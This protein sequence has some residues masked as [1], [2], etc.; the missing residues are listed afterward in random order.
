MSGRFFAP[1]IK[2]GGIFNADNLRAYQ[3]T[4]IRQLCLWRIVKLARSEKLFPSESRPQLSQKKIPQFRAL[5]K[6]TIPTVS[7]V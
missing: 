4:G 7:R 2:T 6:V 5:K 1:T 3:P